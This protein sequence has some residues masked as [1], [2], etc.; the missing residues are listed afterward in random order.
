LKQ[1]ESLQKT[2]VLGQDFSEKYEDLVQNCI[3]ETPIP[4]ASVTVFGNKRNTNF[5]RRYMGVGQM[6]ATKH[7]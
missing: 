4:V 3:A 2:Q 7:M 5:K 1:Q 6:I